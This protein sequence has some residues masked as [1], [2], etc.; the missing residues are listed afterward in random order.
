MSAGRIDSGAS[1]YRWAAPNVLRMSQ[2]FNIKTHE[3]QT[4]RLQKRPSLGLVPP[5]SGATWTLS[6]VLFIAISPFS[7]V[8]LQLS[9]RPRK[10]YAQPQVPLHQPTPPAEAPYSND[11]QGV[12]RSYPHGHPANGQAI[13]DY[14]GHA[15]EEEFDPLDDKLVPF[16]E[17]RQLDRGTCK[18]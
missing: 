11:N 1:L 12:S 7:D 5:Q 15:P 4:T 14:F 6:S 10:K 16:R 13:H 2:G 18:S 3:H 8:A 17:A 9:E